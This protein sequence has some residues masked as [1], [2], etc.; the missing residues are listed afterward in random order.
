MNWVFEQ[1]WDLKDDSIGV[2]LKVAD[3]RR[4][5][6]HQQLFITYGDRANSFLLVEYGFSVPDNPFDFV[7]RSELTLS[8]F[9]S[10]EELQAG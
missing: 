1:V 10:Q 4:V 9:Y 5:K 2:G 6:R 3:G 8:T 7:R